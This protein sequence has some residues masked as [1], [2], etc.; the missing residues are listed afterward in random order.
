MRLVR[1][2][3]MAAA[4]GALVAGCGSSGPSSSSGGSNGIANDSASQIVT[5]AFN[6]LKSAKSVKVISG[7]SNTAKAAG[8]SGQFYSGGDVDATVS[9]GGLS[10]NLIKIG[11]TDYVRAGTSFWTSSGFPSADVSKIANVWVIAPDS[12]VHLGSQYTLTALAGSLDK[13]LG[14]LTKGTTTTING[15]PAIEVISSTQGTIYVATTGTAYPIEAIAKAGS[16]KTGA[17]FSDWDQAAVPTAPA[18]A[19]TLTQLGL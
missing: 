9:E 15:Q 3:I 12:Q 19:K 8:L 5:T 17:Q 10:L 14:T 1:I 13:D 4:A 16:G 7:P 18:G 2:V 6:N 11:P